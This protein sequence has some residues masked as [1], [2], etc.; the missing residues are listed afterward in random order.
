MLMPEDLYQ[1]VKARAEQAGVSVTSYMLSLVEA[2]LA[3]DPTTL[4]TLSSLCLRVRAI[5][6]HLGLDS[7]RPGQR[8]ETGLQVETGSAAVAPS[9]PWDGQ[10]RRRS[11]SSP[12]DSQDS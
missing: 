10:E 4:T 1:Q 12:P 9:G 6:L 7:R 2:D 5:E 8:I 3:A 11:A